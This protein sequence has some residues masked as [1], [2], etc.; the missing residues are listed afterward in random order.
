MKI[1][2]LA[3]GVGGAK[4]ADGLYRALPAGHLTVIVNTCDDFSHLGL[5][6]CPDL[7]TVCY[8][9]AGMASQSTG[10]GREGESFAALDEVI[11]LGGPDWFR[12]GDRDLG[13]HLVRTQRLQNGEPLSKITSDFCARWGIY[14]TVLPMSND[15]VAT[16]V[17]TRQDGDL[18][19]QEYFVRLK[20][21]P[22]VTGFS[23]HGIDLTSPA[24]GVLEAIKAADAVVIC[25]SNPWVSIAPILAL[26]GLRKA[27]Q[28]KS[29]VM[30]VSPLIGGQALK[31]PAAKMFTELGWQPSAKAVANQYRD[32]LKTFLLDNADGDDCD[33]IRQWGIIPYATDIFM[34]DIPG[35]IRLANE[36][37]G[38]IS[39]Q[40][41]E[42][43]PS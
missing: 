40:L 25:P 27:L 8:T 17:H 19:F 3:G 41:G 5:R 15:P 16:I 32:F 20:C 9:L 23:F 36:I 13:T 28:E 14:A 33:A 39:N 6:I 11:A 34:A 7:D 37:L 30:A 26:S 35:R 31:G 18:A 24:P 38:L 43:Q 21:Q 10:W 22:E 12:L 1:V 42:S 4:L 2:A 29:I